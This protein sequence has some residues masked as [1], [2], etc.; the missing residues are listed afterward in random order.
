MIE[1]KSPW[2]K[3]NQKKPPVS[4]DQNT[5]TFNISLGGISGTFKNEGIEAEWSPPVISVVRIRE[6]GTNDWI[7]G[8][9]TPLSSCAFTNLKP[10]TDYEIEVRGKNEHGEGEP[11]LIKTRTTSDGSLGAY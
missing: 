1:L 3:V 4:W 11:T 8:F 5:K 10:D 2:K 7:V 9:E 6:A